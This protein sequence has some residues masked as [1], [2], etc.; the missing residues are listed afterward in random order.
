MDS[1]TREALLDMVKNVENSLSPAE[2]AMGE[3]LVREFMPDL[4]AKQIASVFAGI[5]VFNVNGYYAFDNSE[6]DPSER[7]LG[8]KLAMMG[9]KFAKLFV[10]YDSK[11]ASDL[12]L[13]E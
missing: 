4:T 8:E 1:Q 3:H 10:Y 11:T 5:A 9:F 13:A 7:E 6:S 12:S 2:I